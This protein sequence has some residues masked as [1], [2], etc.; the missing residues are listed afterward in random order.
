MLKLPRLLTTLTFL[1]MLAACSFK[2]YESREWL[3]YEQENPQAQQ[4]GQARFMLDGL[5]TLSLTGL[6]EA[7][8]LP[9]KVYGTA[10]LIAQPDGLNKKHT[11]TELSIVMQKYGFIRP[12]NIGNWNENLAPQPKLPSIQGLIHQTLDER[13]LNK[14]FDVEVAN[15][16]CAACHSG[17]SYDAQGKAT[18]SVWLGA[19]NTSLNFDGFL[20]DIY[21]GLKIAAENPNLFLAKLQETYSEVSDAEIRTLKKELLPTVQKE[22]T[23]MMNSSDSVLPFPNGGPGLTNGVGAFKRDAKLLKKPYHF[24]HSEAGFVSIPDIS[25]RG[26][27]SSLTYDGVYG[28][29]GKPR[30]YEVDLSLA[31]DPRHL[32]SL[33]EIASFFTFSAMGNTMDNAEKA[34]P[35]VQ[36]ILQAM[37]TTGAMK[38]PGPIDKALALEGE[39]VYSKNCA[40]CHGTY[41]RDI[42]SPKL[43]TFPNKFVLQKEMNTDPLRWQKVTPEVKKYSDSV[44]I[45]RHVNSGHSLGG[46]TSPI[47][48]GL[49]YT[50]PYLHN[51]SVPTIWQLMNPELRPSKFQIGGHALDFS[52]LG[53][54]GEM[55]DGIFQYPSS[56]EPWSSPTVYDTTKLGRNNSGHESEFKGL[57]L[58]QKI[59]LMEYLKL[60]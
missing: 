59:S 42:D 48:S 40:S 11:G 36:E 17:V 34:I 24:D 54:L 16:T 22:I 47:L 2:S 18:R 4:V 8:I 31:N 5:Y 55:T 56:H 6:N 51:G 35:R 29:L 39:K 53:I 33:A 32:K 1:P 52:N 23:K 46:Y 12:T 3:E 41:S 57:T 10:L 13:I 30:F 38:F 19:P 9:I 37:S 26:F 28:V 49:W 60:L 14:K 15:I 27:R 43:L 50:A 25:Y 21:K 7:N 58:E 20:G 45:S 44:A